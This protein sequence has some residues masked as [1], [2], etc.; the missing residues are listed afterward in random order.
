M[1]ITS[2]IYIYQY[3]NL[4]KGWTLATSV[5]LALPPKES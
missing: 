5:V 1:I 4:A 2:S 3:T